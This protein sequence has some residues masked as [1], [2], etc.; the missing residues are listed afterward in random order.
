MALHALSGRL[1]LAGRDGT[2]EL[3]DGPAGRETRTLDGHTRHVTGLAFSPDGSRLVSA[4]DDRTLKLW[5]AG[6]GQEALTL[7]IGDAT[8]I[9]VAF[10]PD[11]HQLAV[12]CGQHLVM[13]CDGT[14][15]SGNEKQDELLTLAGHT[16]LV[17]RVAFDR[18]GRR[19]VSASQDGTAR[20]WD[21]IGGREPVIFRGHTGIVSAAAFSPDGEQVASAGWDGKVLVWDAVTREVAQTLSGASVVYDV[22]FSPDGKLLASAHASGTVILW[23]PRTGERVRDIPAHG[24]EA[25]SV[26]FS[27]NG[28]LLATAG[29]RDHTAK[30]WKVPGGEEALQLDM[31]GSQRARGRVWCIGFSPNGKLLATVGHGNATGIASVLLWDAVTGKRLRRLEAQAGRNCSLAF[32][33]DSQWVAS[34]G[35]DETVRAWEV[36]TGEELRP[37]RGHAGPALSVTFSPDG[38]LLASCG[39]YK[40]RGEIKV[41]DAT[42]WDKD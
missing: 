33:P 23:D 7:E 19:L 14:P 10:A 2:V 5:D 36:T 39:G 30:V 18:G 9:G 15:L 41:W 29:G 42:Q 6:S 27:P 32:S 31:E 8:P 17:L 16:D 26:E 11:G 38:R 24:Y 4:A 37:L 28:L 20:V 21:L 13:V 1:A 3:R 40:G 12:A 34:G 25:V 35:W 22:A